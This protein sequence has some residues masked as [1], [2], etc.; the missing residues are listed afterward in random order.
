MP[1]DTKWP[2]S[3]RKRLPNSIHPN[4][5]NLFNGMEIFSDCDI[6]EFL[7]H[8]TSDTANANE[9]SRQLID[10]YGTLSAVVSAPVHK[11]YAVSQLLEPAVFTLKLVK[12]TS[13][14]LLKSEI[15]KKSILPIS[16]SL[17]NYLKA[18]YAA[19]KNEKST[20]LYLD[21]NYF[22][23]SCEPHSSGTI[24]RTAFYAREVM[25][26]GL[27][28]GA[29][30]FILVHNHPGGNVSPSPDDITLSRDMKE[31]MSFFSMTLVDHIIIGDDSWTSLK[32]HGYLD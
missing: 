6:L 30:G 5:R 19:E 16:K 3:R 1:G 10:H 28:L 21:K 12:E 7:I 25:K 32:A 17:I 20:V 27:E 2:V 9:T 31:A 24:D 26:R 18:V 4:A 15:S 22:L 14:R 11:L 13:L 23:L 8:L 29:T